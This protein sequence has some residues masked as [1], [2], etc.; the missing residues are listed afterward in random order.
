MMRDATS[1]TEIILRPLRED[2]FT[3]RYLAWFRDPDVTRFLD[4]SDITRADAVSHLRQGQDGEKWRLYA[5]C[6]ND[7]G[8]HIGNLKLG[9]IHWRH[10]Y[11]DLVTVIGDRP[12]WGR[13]YARASIRKGIDIAFN[14]LNLRKLSASIDLLNVASIKAYTAAGFSI[15]ARLADQFMREENGQLILSEKIYVA[16]FNRN[17]DPSGQRERAR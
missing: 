11:S 3:D 7:N 5:I 4:A 12:S 2:D 14:E 8:S 15:E 13:G 16:C 17:Y 10:G 9:P 1:A 6:R